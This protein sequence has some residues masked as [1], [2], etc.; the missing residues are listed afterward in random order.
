MKGS[1]NHDANP[2]PTGWI[3][4]IGVS[5]SYPGDAG[6]YR[7]VNFQPSYSYDLTLVAG[8]DVV[9]DLDGESVPTAVVA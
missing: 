3:N 5:F 7:Y 1:Q 9:D 2:I 6:L 8:V 4:R